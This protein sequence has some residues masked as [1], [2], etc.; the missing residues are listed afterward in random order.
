MESDF[1]FMGIPLDEEVIHA[2]SK[3]E[4]KKKIKSLIQS[5]APEYL[6]KVESLKAGHG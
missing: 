1:Y 4:Y 3:I 2:T 5:A 6:N